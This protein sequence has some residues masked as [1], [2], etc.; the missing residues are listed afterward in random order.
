MGLTILSY[1]QRSLPINAND[2]GPVCL[3]FFSAVCRE[4]VSQACFSERSFACFSGEVLLA[5][6]V[7]LLLSRESGCCNSD[8]LCKW[9]SYYSPANN[10]DLPSHTA[11]YSMLFLF[12]HF[13]L[14]SFHLSSA[15]GFWSV[16]VR[17]KSPLVLAV[18]GL[19]AD[20]KSIRDIQQGKYLKSEIYYFS[21]PLPREVVTIFLVLS[22]YSLQFMISH[23][24][25]GYFFIVAHLSLYILVIDYDFFVIY[26]FWFLGFFVIS[27][28]TILL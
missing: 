12:P 27:S 10:Y 25:F 3:T 26:A 1:Q 17:S 16:L 11:I 7:F 28:L 8:A 18:T 9:T 21:F 4:N 20:D 13:C 19:E 24:L 6:I 2:L 22:I 5:N 15:Q 23:A 14:S